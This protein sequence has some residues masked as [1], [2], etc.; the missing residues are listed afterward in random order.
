[1]LRAQRR[2]D[3]LGASSMKNASVRQASPLLFSALLVCTVAAA[4]APQSTNVAP[5]DAALAAYFKAETARISDRCL[6]DVRTLD[7]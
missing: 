1:M 6:A 3:T 2:R 7:D 5:G 4:T